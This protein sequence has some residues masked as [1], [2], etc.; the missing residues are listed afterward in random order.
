MAS[1]P[2]DSEIS[3]LWK[4]GAPPARRFEPL[5]GEIEADVAIVGAGIAGLSA[6]YHLARLDIRPV[7]LEAAEPGANAAGKSGGIIASLPARQRPARIMKNHGEVAGRRL[8]SLYAESGR[9]TFSLIDRLGLNCSPQPSGFIAPARAG[10]RVRG[11]S[12]ISREWRTFGHDI[13]YLDRVATRDL[14]GLDLYDGALLD[15][16]GGALN[17][18][19][20]AA[21]LAGASADAGAGIFTGSPVTACVNAAGSWRL[22]TP[23]GRVDAKRVLLCAGG[24]NRGLS[25]HLCRASMPLAAYQFATEPLS[26]D[27]REAVLPEGHALTDVHTDIF[28]IRYDTEG[29][30]ITACAAFLFSNSNERAVGAM[31]RRLRRVSSLFESIRIQHVWRGTA[32]LGRSLTPQFFDLSDGLFAIQACNGRGLAVNT[33]LGRRVAEF[34]AFGS[35]ARAQLTVERPAAIRPYSLMRHAPGLYAN[36]ARCRNLVAGELGAACR[37]GRGRKRWN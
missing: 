17:P 8:I 3:P 6:A 30:L 4:L 20:Y 31:T 34:V 24:D 28:T 18:Y 36:A 32:W 27:V 12:G 23:E 21:E 14:T 11:L 29:R 22:S 10:R 35:E 25:G 7:V 16:H 37:F 5:D 26:A 2:K 33:L 1:R 19:A 13:R 9:Y 15:P